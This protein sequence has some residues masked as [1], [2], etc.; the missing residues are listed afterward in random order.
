MFYGAGHKAKR[1]VLQ[2]INSESSNAVEGRKNLQFKDLILTQF[3][4]IF[5]R[6][7]ISFIQL[8]VYI[9]F[10]QLRT[11]LTL[12]EYLYEISW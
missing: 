4:L 1:L 12:V 6:I 10:N 3:G 11:P 2:C 5:R 8:I 9:S 7:Y